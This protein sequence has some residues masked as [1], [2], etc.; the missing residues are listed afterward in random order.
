MYKL[1]IKSHQ[2]TPNTTAAL[3]S[4]LTWP[5]RRDCNI[6]DK[7]ELIDISKLQNNLCQQKFPIS[8]TLHRQSFQN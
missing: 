1:N 4:E 6:G 2:Q 5:I 8:L 7:S 3:K